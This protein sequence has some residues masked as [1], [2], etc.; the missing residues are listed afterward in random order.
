L[1]SGHPVDPPGARPHRRPA[2]RV[3]SMLAFSHIVA[4]VA[5]GSPTTFQINLGDLPTWL[6][7]VAAS[8][9]AYFVYGQLRSQ[10]QQLNG[11]QQEIARQAA[12][13]E[14][15]QPNKIDA[16]LWG[17]DMPNPDFDPAS[18]DFDPVNDYADVATSCWAVRVDNRSERPIREVVARIQESP[19]AGMTHASGVITY[20]GELED[21]G[22]TER[23]RPDRRMHWVRDNAS[24]VWVPGDQLDF[25]RTG[26]F[27]AVFHFE[28]SMEEHPD[29]RM[30]VRF[31]DD[32]GLD[33]QIDHELHLQRLQPRDW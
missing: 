25:L 24:E 5:V 11:Q 3:P 14:R 1:A 12:A 8:V 30:T 22:H 4:G 16:T 26:G 29:P 20:A 27:H 31:T 33:W 23:T 17:W 9:A 32:A 6:G 10:Q 21:L 13:L 15:Q 19:G 18:P 2:A 28:V 7:V